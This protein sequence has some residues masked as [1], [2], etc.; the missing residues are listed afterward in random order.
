MGT[1]EKWPLTDFHQNQCVEDVVEQII[2]VPDISIHINRLNSHYGGEE[3]L[4]DMRSL[5]V[6]A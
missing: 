6:A 3:Y 5:Q 4:A 2:V 1:P